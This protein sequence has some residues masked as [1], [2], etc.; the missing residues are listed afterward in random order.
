MAQLAFIIAG[1]LLIAVS[2]AS[3]V[4]EADP[5]T[6]QG[7]LS[8]H[9]PAAAQHAST[10]SNVYVPQ[11]LSESEYRVAK[12]TEQQ[13]KNRKDIITRKQGFSFFQEGFV[14]LDS[15]RTS[16]IVCFLWFGQI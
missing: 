11:G 12:S 6:V 2:Q 1:L 4:E 14:F 3:N 9:M 16:N 7:F 13:Q 15:Y 8:K 10:S 5:S